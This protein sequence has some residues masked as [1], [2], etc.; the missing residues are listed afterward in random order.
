VTRVAV[1]RLRYDGSF[2]LPFA[3]AAAAAM[4]ILFVPLPRNAVVLFAGAALVVALLKPPL[5]L[6]CLVA[7]VPVQ[8]VGGEPLGPIN[9]TLTKFVLLATAAAWLAR[10]LTQH[11][12]LRLDRIVVTHGL[13]VVVLALSIVN[14]PAG[15]SWGAELY[16]WWSPLLTYVI[17]INTIRRPRDARPV[18]AGTALGVVGASVY[19][20]V[21]SARGIGPEAFD[22]GGWTRAYATFGQPNPFAGYLELTVPLLVA[23]SAAWLLPRYRP[24]LRE[25]IGGP[26]AALSAVGSGIGLIA[27]VLTQSR[28][29]WLGA[30]AGLTVVAVLLGGRIRWTAVAVGI[31]VFAAV[32]L[33]PYGNRLSARLVAGFGLQSDGVQVTTENFAVQ[34]R[35]AH[36][37]AG[38]AMAKRYPVLG[39]GAGSFPARFREFTQVWRFRIQRGHAHNAYIHAA[40]Q[41]G[42]VGLAAYLIFLGGVATS[43]YRSLRRAADPAVRVVVVGAIGVT[44]ALAVHNVFDYLHVHSL[45]VQLAA[46]WAIASTTTGDTE[47]RSLPVARTWRSRIAASGVRAG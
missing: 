10:V 32:I 45:P 30:V 28:G 47:A 38:W 31:A 9:L 19:G 33:T 14:A 29:G 22:V 34:E 40:A 36:W 2:G 16:R 44:V 35:L 25:A 43:L 23:L 46:V 1:G 12:P 17:A 39:V 11:R 26:L 15:A 21:Q 4:V 27:L 42:F 5:A 7:S 20:I 6:G 8:S 18:I 13:Y 37:R 3:L 41:S 24:A